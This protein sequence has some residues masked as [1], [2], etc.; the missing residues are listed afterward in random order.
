MSQMNPLNIARWSLVWFL[1]VGLISMNLA[2][3]MMSSKEESKPDIKRVFCNNNNNNNNNNNDNNNNNND[4]NNWGLVKRVFWNN[5][6]NN[7]N[8]NNY[9]NNNNNNNNNWRVECPVG[10]KV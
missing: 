10:I 7:N 9:N 4:N 8:N 6:D 3:K 2:V 5:N 1:L